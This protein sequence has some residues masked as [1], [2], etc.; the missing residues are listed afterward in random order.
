MSVAMQ[1]GNIAA[2]RAAVERSGGE[3]T[4]EDRLYL[5]AEYSVWR[6][7]NDVLEFLFESD[8]NVL[9][10][11]GVAGGG[12]FPQSRLRGQF[13]QLRAALR[14]DEVYILRNRKRFFGVLE[15]PLDTFGDETPLGYDVGDLISD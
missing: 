15:S 12:L 1:A 7:D 3:I 11:R 5:R 10:L 2:L 14:W 13:E 8:D 4:V 9:E 6:G